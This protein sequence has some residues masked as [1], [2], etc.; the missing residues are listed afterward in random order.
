VVKE[1]DA[2]IIARVV[3]RPLFIFSL[4]EC[5]FRTQIE[6]SAGT[7]VMVDTFVMVGIYGMYGLVGN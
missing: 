4:F 7:F 5:R 1:G 2:N 3:F 6:V